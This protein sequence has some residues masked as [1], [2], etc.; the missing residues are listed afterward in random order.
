MSPALL[1][2]LVKREDIEELRR[3][4]AYEGLEGGRGIVLEGA[5]LK[6]DELLCGG[7][8]SSVEF[9]NHAGLVSV[10]IQWMWL[11]ANQR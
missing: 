2:C 9:H 5:A 10:V 11:D 8:E 7:K 1:R 4:A 3:M 6:W